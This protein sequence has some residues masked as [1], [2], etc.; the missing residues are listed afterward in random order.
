MTIRI[1]LASLVYVLQ[2]Y[3]GTVPLGTGNDL[4]RVLGWGSA[5]D[6]DDKLFGILKEME[7]SAVQMLD[8]FVLSMCVRVCVRYVCAH[9]CVDLM[10]V[11]MHA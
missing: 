4:S 8:R 5:C 11:S 3:I 9:A 6:D 7:N 10:N 2:C 1:S